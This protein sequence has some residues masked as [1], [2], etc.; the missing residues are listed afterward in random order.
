[1]RLENHF[2]FIGS[3]MGMT[4]AAGHDRLVIFRTVRQVWTPFGQQMGT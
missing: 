1:M 4:V 3:R 2:K